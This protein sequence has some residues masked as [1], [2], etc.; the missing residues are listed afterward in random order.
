M[1]IRCNRIDVLAIK[2]EK[3]AIQVI[4]DILLCHREVDHAKQVL[5]IFLRQGDRCIKSGR[6]ADDR[7]ILG[8]QCLE[9]EA[10]TSS[11]DNQFLVIQGK[12]HV[13]SVWQRTQ[14]ILQLAC[15]YS[16]S[17]ILFIRADRCMGD[18]LDFSIRRE[19]RNVIALFAD[20]DVG[21]DRQCLTAF[22][23]AADSLQ[24]TEDFITASFNQ[25]HNF[26][27]DV[28]RVS[29]NQIGSVIMGISVSQSVRGRAAHD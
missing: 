23:N 22:H 26:S 17:G 1:A 11:R 6:L 20:Q 14:D 8:R 7:E 9:R 19:E 25:L 12:G 2:L 16:C 28:N 24:G 15:R 10:G 29:V 3:E 5:Q 4:A 21:K 13:R 27:L 18:N